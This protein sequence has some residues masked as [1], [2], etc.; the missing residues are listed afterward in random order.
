MLS[1]FCYRL[2]NDAT[3]LMLIIPYLLPQGAGRTELRI[4]APKQVAG[5]SECQRR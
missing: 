1:I 5:I 2:F 4:K 3:P